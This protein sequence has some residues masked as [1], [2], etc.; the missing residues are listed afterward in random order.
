MNLPQEAAGARH[1]FDGCL[2]SE[3]VVQLS[4]PLVAFGKVTDAATG[5][6]VKEFTVTPVQVYR[7]KF[8]TT[9]FDD[10]RAGKDGRRPRRRARDVHR[11]EHRQR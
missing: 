6:S 11:P 2:E 1:N 4:P 5:A 9:L 7:P 3:H 10:S 8:M